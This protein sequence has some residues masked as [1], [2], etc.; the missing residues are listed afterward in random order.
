MKDV[1]SRRFDLEINRSSFP[2]ALNDPQV[3]FHGINKSGSLAMAN[4]LVEAFQSA[5]RGDDVFSHYHAGGKDEDFKNRVDSAKGRSGFVVGH[6]LYGALAPVP[7]RIWITQ[8]RHPL[9]RILSCYQWLKNKNAKV[10]GSNSK[11]PSLT[12]FVRK[13]NGVTHSQ[14][15]QFGCGFGRNK[16]AR[17]NGASAADLFEIAVDE[18]ESN[19][20]AIGIAEHFEESIFTF[21]ALCGLDSVA[22]WTRDNRNKNRPLAD[23]ITDTERQVIEEVYSNDFKLYE[24]ALDRFWQQTGELKLDAVSSLRAYKEACQDQYKDRILRA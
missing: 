14:V 6:Y 19:V 23:E 7:N 24:Y 12:E 9:P 18:I 10:H 4:T 8:F 17:L 15:M 13:T 1:P 5:G 16:P 3:V 22:P 2:H 11:Y 20:Y 21:A